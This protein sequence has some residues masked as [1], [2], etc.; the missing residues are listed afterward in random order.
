[1]NKAYD[2]PTTAGRH[3]KATSGRRQSATMGVQCSLQQERANVRDGPEERTPR[4][5]P[6]RKPIEAYAVATSR[7]RRFSSVMIATRRLN[8]LYSH[9]S[10]TWRSWPHAHGM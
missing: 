1:M 8:S 7:R 5:P 9:F 3:G 2:T 6:L 10:Y 4:A